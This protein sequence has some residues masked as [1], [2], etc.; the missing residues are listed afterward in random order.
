MTSPLNVEDSPLD[1]L[2]VEKIFDTDA[3]MKE[4]IDRT[5]DFTDHERWL[6]VAGLLFTGIQGLTNKSAAI[7][8]WKQLAELNYADAHGPLG[9]LLIRGADLP[10]NIDKGISHLEHAANLGRHSSLRTLISLYQYGFDGIEPDLEKAVKYMKRA[11]DMGDVE[12]MLDLSTLLASN[13]HNDARGAF[14]YAELAAQADDPRGHYNVGRAYER[15]LGID[16]N[17]EKAFFHYDFAAKHGI[18]MAQH[19][20]AALYANGTGVEQ[21]YKQARLWYMIAS[22]LKSYMSMQNLGVMSEN[23]QGDAKNPIRALA[24]YQLASEAGSTMVDQHIKRLMRDFTEA[25]VQEEI[26]ELRIELSGL[27]AKLREDL[28]G[29]FETN[30]VIGDSKMEVTE[31]NQS[32]ETA[33][34]RN[35]VEKAELIG[36]TLNQIRGL[37]LLYQWRLTYIKHISGRPISSELFTEFVPQELAEKILPK[38][39]SEEFF[40]AVPILRAAGQALNTSLPEKRVDKDGQPT[41]LFDFDATDDDSVIETLGPRHEFDLWL[42]EE[43]GTV[44]DSDASAADYFVL[45]Q[46]LTELGH[47]HDWEGFRRIQLAIALQPS[48]IIMSLT[49][50][51]LVTEISRFEPLEIALSHLGYG[52]SS[53]AEITWNASKSYLY[54]QIVPFPRINQELEFEDATQFILKIMDKIT[55]YIAGQMNQNPNLQDEIG[56]EYLSSSFQLVDVWQLVEKLIEEKFS[57]LHLR[58]L[59]RPSTLLV[60]AIIHN[61]MCHVI[62]KNVNAWYESE[63][64][65]GGGS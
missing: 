7:S 42:L 53:I 10:L 50:Y 43:L 34:Y 4:F 23:G 35:W 45:A 28:P 11:A 18:V 54:E 36:F 15:G 62:M 32:L 59:N 52:K 1:F 37:A 5:K 29:W 9:E 14:K 51:D 19:N 40:K 24:W 25:Q 63:A 57:A 21:D 65:P 60:N 46:H 2:R 31:S 3:A 20:M 33:T 49:D 41:D 55:P 48:P 47:E 30:Q 12:R 39:S 64:K 27:E 44:L 56:D 8:I 22:V 6:E 61:E 26:A 38:F 13:P 17:F 58:S 16:Q